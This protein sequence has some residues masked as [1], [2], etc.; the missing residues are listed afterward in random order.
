MIFRLLPLVFFSSLGLCQGVPI[1]FGL[2]QGVRILAF[3][4]PNCAACKSLMT[5]SGVPLIFVGRQDSQEY[6]PYI[7]DS[8]D[9]LARSFRIQQAPTVII[10]NAGLEVKRFVLPNLPDAQLLN[11]ALQAAQ[12]GLITPGAQEFLRLGIVHVVMM[13]EVAQVEVARAGETAL[14]FVRWPVY[15]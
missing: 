8:G 12:A 4:A 14:R 1:G 11:L 7:K 9:I 10:T 15:L 13:G 6:A 3:I 5:I 2:E